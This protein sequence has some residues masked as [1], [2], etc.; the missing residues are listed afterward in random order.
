VEVE[1]SVIVVVPLMV[2]VSGASV[3]TPPSVMV[4]LT[5]VV[6]VDASGVIVS[7]TS[8]VTTS[9]EVE[10]TSGEMME[11]VAVSFWVLVLTTS[12]PEIANVSVA[13]ARTVDVTSDPKTTVLVV[14]VAVKVIVVYTVTTGRLLTGVLDNAKELLT[15]A[16]DKDAELVTAGRLMTDVLDNFREL[17]EAVGRRDKLAV[18]EAEAQV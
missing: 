11:M 12:T 18:D 17:V 9:V 4:C 15:D 14:I 5:T 1:R 16:L 2:I 3:V 6:F 7:P 13:F 10:I 8:S